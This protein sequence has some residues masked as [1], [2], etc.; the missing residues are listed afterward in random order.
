MEHFTNVADK[1]IGAKIRNK[2]FN[3]SRRDGYLGG[4]PSVSP[5]RFGS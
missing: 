4:R 1:D 2:I 3:C 5:S